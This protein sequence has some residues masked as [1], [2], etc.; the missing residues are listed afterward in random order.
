MRARAAQGVDL[1]LDLVRRA[2]RELGD[3]DVAG[4]VGEHAPLR[5]HRHQP[6]AHHG[7]VDRIAARAQERQLDDGARLAA[8]Q[9]LAGGRRERP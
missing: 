1:A 7:E 5:R 4:R 2:R 9:A 8:Q 6:L 3:L